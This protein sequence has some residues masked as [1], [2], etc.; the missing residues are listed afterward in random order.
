[1]KPG[2]VVVDLAAEAG[3]NIETTKPGQLYK[4]HDVTHIGYTDFPSRLAS[5][6]SQLYSNNITKML[7]SFTGWL[8]NIVNKSASCSCSICWD[9]GYQ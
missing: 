1:M 9:L 2:S 6:S 5:T 8:I 4:Y 7:L 3:G